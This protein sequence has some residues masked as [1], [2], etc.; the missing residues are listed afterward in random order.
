MAAGARPLTVV[1]AMEDD[2]MLWTRRGFLAWAGGLAAITA[3]PARVRA[4]A[5]S[6]P[7]APPAAADA[8]AAARADL[9]RLVMT[10]ALVGDDPWVLMHV[11]LPLGAEAR[12]GDARVL[13][14]VLAAWIA[15]VSVGGKTYAA[16]PLDVERHPNHFLEVMYEIGVAPGRSFMTKVGPVTRT[17]LTNAAKALFSP[18]AAGGEL[19]WTVSVFTAAIPA[20]RD[21][22]ENAEGRAFTVS[23]LVEVLAQATEAAYADTAAAMRGTKPYGRSPLQ[24]LP[25]NGTHVLGGILDALSHGY[26]GNKLAERATALVRAATFRLGSE[27]ALI[28]QAIGRSGGPLAQLNA[29]AAK[30]Q[31]LGHSLETLG[32]ARRRSLFAPTAAELASIR[33]AEEELAAVARRL[34]ATHDLAVLERQVPRA[35]KIVLGDACHALH[36]LGPAAA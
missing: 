20:D 34:V 6:T 24:T 26:R 31:F 3:F 30:L 13:D 22:F 32:F 1:D 29:D 15:P 18:A 2:W 16:F 21:G 19:S 4:A 10:R 9:Q 36:A 7:V 25:C 17:D 28:D 12:R 35:Y 23:A 14:S 8:N 27:V 5:T 11:L 33:A